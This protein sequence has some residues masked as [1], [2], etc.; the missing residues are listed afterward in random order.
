V[1]NPHNAAGEEDSEL[2]R[3]TKLNAEI[4]AAAEES[5][6]GT[7]LDEMDWI[8]VLEIYSEYGFHAYLMYRVA[9][10]H[11]I[12]YLYRSFSSKEPYI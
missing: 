4:D 7:A 9:K 12:P 6:A 10:T 5:A 11:R 3:N 8:N 1:W 2:A